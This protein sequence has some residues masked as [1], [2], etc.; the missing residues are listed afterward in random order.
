VGYLGSFQLLAITIKAT[1]N[2]EEDVP[3]WCGGASFG[4]MS[5]SGIVG[6]SGRSISNF[7]MNLQIYFQSGSTSLQSH[8]QWRSVPHS[9]HPRHHEVLILAIL[10]GVRWNLRVVLV[11]ISLITKDF[12]YFFRCFLAIWVFFFLCLAKSNDN[13]K[14]GI[15]RKSW[16][17]WDYVY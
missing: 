8:Q 4:N 3:L 10:T 15:E 1:M 7:L 14:N 12:E 17:M 6:S 16:A 9:S 2:I 11:C 5:K 13:M